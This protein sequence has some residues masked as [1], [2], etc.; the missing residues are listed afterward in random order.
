MILAII[1]AR[2]SSTRL[3]G[4]VMKEILGKPLIGYLLDRLNH[5]KKI[6]KITVATSTDK[7]NDNL[8]WYVE[9]IGF[10]V[11]R[12]SEDDVL[13]RFYEAALKYKPEFILRITGDCPLIDPEI[14][15]RLIDAYLKE[16]A[17]YMHLD[18]TFAEGLDCEIFSFSAL[19]TAH[20]NA[21]LKSEREHVTRYFHNHPGRFNK[22]IL[23]NESDDS[24]YRITADEPQDFEVLEVIIKALNRHG[25]VLSSFKEIKVFLNNHPEI[26]K[27]NSHIIRNEGL[28]KS[29]KNDSEVKL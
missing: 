15:D 20:K 17:D 24:R 27:I 4:K 14:C 2:V 19:E 13:S 29:L 11:Y 3:P 9:S 18:S 28:I 23:K 26:M 6:N 7:S 5:S 1:Q 12:G 21:K 16:K 22:I 25:S 8:C 10:E